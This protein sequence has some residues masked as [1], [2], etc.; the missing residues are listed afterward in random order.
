[1]PLSHNSCD[2]RLKVCAT[3]LVSKCLLCRL[4]Q[5]EDSTEKNQKLSDSETRLEFFVK[6]MM[7]LCWFWIW[8]TLLELDCFTDSMVGPY[9]AV[10]LSWFLLKIRSARILDTIA[11]L[12][13]CFGCF[14]QPWMQLNSLHLS[15]CGR[16]PYLFKSN[17]S[18]CAGLMF[19]HLQPIP[20]TEYLP[21]YLQ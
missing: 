20:D 17:N 1:M 7:V 10:L 16:K 9:S 12:G 18:S 19:D 5:Y 13:N 3:F 8:N 4:S 15:F 14:L 6:F 2:C 11:C 21:F